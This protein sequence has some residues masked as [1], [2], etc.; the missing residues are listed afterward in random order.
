MTAAL[1]SFMS[2][3]SGFKVFTGCNNPNKKSQT[4]LAR[5]WS[6]HRDCLIVNTK[7]RQK[8]TLQPEKTIAIHKHGFQITDGDRSNNVLKLLDMHC[9]LKIMVG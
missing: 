3:I 4:E 6:Y 9:T 7:P 8:R 2:F 5:D 1:L